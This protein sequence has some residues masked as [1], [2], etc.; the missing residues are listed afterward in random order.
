MPA[1]L[2]PLFQSSLYFWIRHPARYLGIR[3][4]GQKVDSGNMVCRTRVLAIQAAE[5]VPC[6]VFRVHET[7][8]QAQ[9][10]TVGGI[11]R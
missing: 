8:I 7:A 5:P 10:G 9:L 2:K 4:S 6:A 3:G 1:F 11:D